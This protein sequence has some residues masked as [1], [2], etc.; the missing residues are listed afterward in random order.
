MWLPERE[1]NTDVER[2]VKNVIQNELKLPEIVNNID[3]LHRTGKIKEK[4]GKR[5]QDVIIRF[6]SHKARYTVYSERKK[7]KNVKISANLTKRRG[8]LLFDATNA[9]RG[10]EKVNFCFANI[11]GDLNVRLEEAYNGKHVHGFNSISELSELLIKTG[12][13]QEPIVLNESR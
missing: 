4:N 9:V 2:E 3:K 1:T 5:M 6:K 11:H 10:V 7:A 12:L 13:T 8:K